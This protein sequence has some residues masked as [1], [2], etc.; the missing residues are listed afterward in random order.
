MSENGRLDKLEERLDEHIKFCETK[1]GEGK[2]QFEEI[3]SCLKN[4]QQDTSGIVQLHRDWQGAARI[5]NGIQ[6]LFTWLL[7]WGTIGT[8][9][10]TMIKWLATHFN[11][12]PSP[13][14]VG[15]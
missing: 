8:I 12:L 10:A 3:L 13:P 11:D 4:L 2:E 15:G 9:L 14:S 5:G 1:F 7:K 6:K